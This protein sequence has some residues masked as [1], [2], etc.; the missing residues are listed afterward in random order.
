MRDPPW[1]HSQKGRDAPTTGPCRR[2]YKDLE[3]ALQEVGE[4]VERFSTSRRC[5]MDFQNKRVEKIPVEPEYAR[6]SVSLDLAR[7]E[8]STNIPITARGM[9]SSPWAVNEAVEH[10]FNR[11]CENAQVHEMPWDDTSG[12]L[13]L[14]KCELGP[15]FLRKLRRWYPEK[16]R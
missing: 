6:G 16:F 2:F 9:K 15:E 3:A 4:P 10:D 7:N 14:E 1:M 5:T 8:V 11:F 12:F 13:F